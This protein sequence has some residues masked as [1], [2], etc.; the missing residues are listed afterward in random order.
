M[1]VYLTC[2]NE[3]AIFDYNKDNN[4]EH[5]FTNLY[6][7]YDDISNALTKNDLKSL[8]WDEWFLPCVNNDITSQNIEYTLSL[9]CKTCNLNDENINNLNQIESDSLSC[10]CYKAG[11]D[12]SSALQEVELT[13]TQKSVIYEQEKSHYLSIKKSEANDESEKNTNSVAKESEKETDL[14]ENVSNFI[15]KNDEIAS[16]IVEKEAKTNEKESTNEKDNVS[17]FKWMDSLS[18]RLAI[19]GVAFTFSISLTVACY[20]FQFKNLLNDKNGNKND[21]YDEFATDIEAKYLCDD[22][23]EFK[24]QQTDRQPFLG[25]TYGSV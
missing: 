18:A 20:L 6:D 12:V 5:Y 11:K 17:S 14:N 15:E 13:A 4:L 1:P 9:D 22:A 19:I 16:K 8:N 24:P 10:I 25:G 2:S 23:D 3:Y 21:Y 7:F